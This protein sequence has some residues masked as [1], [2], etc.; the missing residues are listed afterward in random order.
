MKVIF[1][2]TFTLFLGAT[3]S[4]Q[5]IKG[6]CKNGKG[7]YIYA[8]NSIYIGDFVDG[9]AE[10]Q[11]SCYYSDGERYTGSW[12]NHDYNG[13]GT[14]HRADGTFEEGYWIDGE[15]SKP[16]DGSFQPYEKPK[17]W[18]VVVGVSRYHHT[19]SLKYSDDDAYRMYAFLRSN[20]GGALPDEQVKVL[21][22]QSATRDKIL[23]AVREIADKAGPND[24]VIFY[25]SGH[26]L[27]DSLLP[28]DYDGIDN[29][30]YH[31]ELSSLL[32]VSNA[33]HKVCMIDACHSGS[34][35]DI[36]VLKGDN[37]SN[38][39]YEAFSLSAGG[40]ALILSSKAEESSVENDGL[41]HGVFSYFLIKGLKG[42]CDLNADNIVTVM[43][44]FNYL[45]YNVPNYTQG[46]QTPVIFGNFD[47]NMP[48]SQI[49][50]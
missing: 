15:L 3:I 24:A 8:D 44:L 42:E 5:C 30:V 50:D 39:I 23:E 27:K 7:V 13:K 10:G 41:R 21:V 40:T 35:E 2:L 47:P 48:L 20:Q 6:D 46:F 11:G 4:A 33:K 36:F 9:K 16:I 17:I 26:G 14:L 28:F 43:E 45:H 31:S 37:I 38:S 19:Y 12:K 34:M 29:K 25:F 1:T 22:D 18:A 32:A 49:T